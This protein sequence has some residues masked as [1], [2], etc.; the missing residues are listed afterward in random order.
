M[1][2][3]EPDMAGMAD[4]LPDVEPHGIHR[5]NMDS[6]RLALDGWGAFGLLHVEWRTPWELKTDKYKQTRALMFAKCAAANSKVMEA[7]SIGKHKS[8]YVHLTLW[9]IPL[10]I[11]EVGDLW[12]FSTDPVEQRGARLKRIARER[13]SPGDRPTMAS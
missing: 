12:P 8:W 7:L 9:V 2:D 3:T 4:A 13:W 6:V 10:Q 5:E 1:S 11:A